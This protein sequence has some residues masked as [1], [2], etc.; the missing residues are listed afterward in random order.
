MDAVD[1][2]RHRDADAQRE[3]ERG[4]REPGFGREH[5]RVRGRTAPG[6]HT[7][8]QPTSASTQPR[9]VQASRS[10]VATN[11]GTAAATIRPHITQ[12][13]D[14]GPLSKRSTCER[15]RSGRNAKPSDALSVPACAYASGH[16]KS[17][18]SAPIDAT[19]AMPNAR[20]VACAARDRDGDDEREHRE[21]EEPDARRVERAEQRGQHREP[22]H[23]TAPRVAALAEADDA[24]EEERQQREQH[25][26]SEP[27]LRDRVAGDGVDPVDEAGRE[28]GPAEPDGEATQA[29][30]T[31]R[32]ERAGRRRR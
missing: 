27:T 21:H 16:G 17:R 20:N 2:H 14:A 12:P 5:R 26:R 29:V 9:A 18:T 22:Q 31:E 7:A 28:R 4:E 24:Q 23:P 11:N 13:A 25:Q 3:S 19:I 1:E 30:R 10:P 6:T 15:S 8:A 32:A